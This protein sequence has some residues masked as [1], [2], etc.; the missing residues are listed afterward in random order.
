MCLP[1]HT[2]QERNEVDYQNGSIRGKRTR[3]G[4]LVCQWSLA[5]P[6]KM[7]SQ[8]GITGHFILTSVFGA[9]PARGVTIHEGL[10]SI[11]NRHGA[12]HA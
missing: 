9:L 7:R 5:L 4:N 3:E 12:E 2:M 1:S 10:Y 11:A 8:I 6:Q